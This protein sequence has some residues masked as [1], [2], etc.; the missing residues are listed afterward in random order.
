M[1]SYPTW[2]ANGASYKP[3][4]TAHDKYLSQSYQDAVHLSDSYLA[5]TL[6]LCQLHFSRP[7]QLTSSAPVRPSMF[8]VSYPFHCTVQLLRYVLST[9]RDELHDGRSTAQMLPWELHHQNSR[10]VLG[11]GT[12][13][14][15]RAGMQ[16]A[17]FCWVGMPCLW[18]RCIAAVRA[19]F[20]TDT[21]R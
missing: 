5:T 15:W 10:L 8:P 3:L 12:D 1:T 16:S 13:G 14:G 9:A 19:M 7:S 2:I 21:Y 20:G 11:S 4:Y 6:C 17:T 18:C